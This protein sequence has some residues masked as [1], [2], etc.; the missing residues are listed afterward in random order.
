MEWFRNQTRKLV[1]PHPT[2]NSITNPGNKSL[3]DSNSNSRKN[4]ASHSSMKENVTI[5][6]SN[7]LNTTSA[8][9]LIRIPLRRNSQQHTNTNVTLPTSRNWKEIEEMENENYSPRISEVLKRE[10]EEFKKSIAEYQRKLQVLT[11]ALEE[12]AEH[13]VELAHQARTD[14]I[15]IKDLTQAVGTLETEK[16]RLL[17]ENNS[18]DVVMNE[19]NRRIETITRCLEVL[20]IENVE[21][22]ALI[23]LDEEDNVRAVF[24]EKKKEF[25]ADPG[26]V[27]LL[28]AKIEEL[29]FKIKHLQ[30]QIIQFQKKDF[31][32]RQTVQ[33]YEKKIQKMHEKTVQNMAKDAQKRK[34][35]EVEV[36]KLEKKV[37]QLEIIL[38]QRE[39]HSSASIDTDLDQENDSEQDDQKV[40]DKDKL[41][42]A[43]D[44]NCN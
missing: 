8:P 33:A 4:S 31:A 15:K 32:Y 25:H 29:E 26:T 22:Q 39:E 5:L 12:K 42:V 27:Q 44:S 21:L 40:E 19:Q 11:S 30:S 18:K 14:E 6:H 28:T 2:R 17:R 3:T 36:E 23:P 13:I 7:S 37:Q 34:L 24:E 10:K 16:E 41:Q 35:T 1:S 38:G 20:A 43:N 9:T